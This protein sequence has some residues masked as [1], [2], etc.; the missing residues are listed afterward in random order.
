MVK[1]NLKIGIQKSNFEVQ[2]KKTY[3]NQHKNQ[4]S[5]KKNENLKIIN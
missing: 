1:S 5:E 4:I 3:K 2:V